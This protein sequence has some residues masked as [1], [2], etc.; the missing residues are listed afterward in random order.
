MAAMSK[1]SLRVESFLTEGL[2]MIIHKVLPAETNMPQ[3][4]RE[5]EPFPVTSA[6]FGP[7]S[8]FIC[9]ADAGSDI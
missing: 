5:E 7:T 8:I 6:L 4:W 1:A 9:S 3:Q 2:A